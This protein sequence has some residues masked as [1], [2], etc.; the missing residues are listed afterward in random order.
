V[1]VD[2]EQLRHC[3]KQKLICVEPI[4]VKLNTC[5]F[6]LKVSVFL[7]IKLSLFIKFVNNDSLNFS[8]FFDIDSTNSN[9]Y[10]LFILRND[11]VEYLYILMAMLTVNIPLLDCL[12][13]L[14]A[15]NANFSLL[16]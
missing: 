12:K 6:V 7:L 2:T 8:D 3:E 13:I 10:F 4:E 14:L 16:S 15:A 9:C 5:I 1:I 11:H